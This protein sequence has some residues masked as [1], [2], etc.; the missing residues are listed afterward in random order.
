MAWRGE[1]PRGRGCWRMPT[2]LEGAA[3]GPS[4]VGASKLVL[5]T[6]SSGYIASR[7]IPRLLERG[8]RVRAMAREPGR[9]NAHPWARSVQIAAADVL[10][11]ET[12][13]AA[14]EGVHTAYYL[15]HNMSL[16]HGYIASEREGARAFAAAARQAGVQHIIYLGGLADPNGHIAAHLRS[17]IETGET[18]RGSGVLVTEFRSG[19]IVGAGSISFEMIRFISEQFP[20][21]PGPTWLRNRTQ[22][23]AIS[24]IMDYL[25]AGLEGSPGGVYEIGGPEVMRYAEAMQRYARMRGLRRVQLFLPGMPVQLMAWFVDRLTPVPFPIA[26][27]LVE[28]LRADSIVQDDAALRQFPSVELIPYEKAMS[29][30]LA[31]THPDRVERV[32]DPAAPELSLKHEGFVID[33]CSLR[34]GLSLAKMWK[35][36]GAPE[37]FRMEASV[38]P[39]WMLLKAGQAFGGQHWLEWKLHERGDGSQLSLTS[40]FAGRGLPGHALWYLKGDQRRAGLRRMLAAAERKAS[41]AGTRVL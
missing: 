40:F 31:G 26:C 16:G 25:L 1:S 20:I 24:N 27:A 32:W 18:L 13:P 8:T 2:H 37:G 9:V 5:V 34:S 36:L 23:I 17:R 10:K 35:S 21:L 15:I 19:A 6:G 11:P 41:G 14:L 29:L 3:R 7:L 28:G 12:L 30:V 4:S 39:E 33:H 22:P 38:P